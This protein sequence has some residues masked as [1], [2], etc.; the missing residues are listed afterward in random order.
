MNLKMVLFDLDG[1]LLPMDM[2]VFIKCYFGSLI[3]K[4]SESGYDQKLLNDAMKYGLGAM[5]KNRGEKTNEDVFWETFATVYGKSKE[6]CTSDFEQFYEKDFDGVSKSCGFTPEARVCIKKLMDMGLPVALAT[7][8]LFPKI[9]TYKRVKWAGLEPSW[10]RLITTYENSRT[11]KPN[12]AYYV[13][14][15]EA[16]GVAPDRCLMVGN[17]VSDDMV[18]Q[19]LG[20]KV[21]LLDS[22]LIN[23]KGEDISR[24]PHGGFAELMEYIKTLV[25]R[26]RSYTVFS[27]YKQEGY[28]IREPLVLR[29]A[30]LQKEGT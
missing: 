26:L 21:F 25:D 24:Y 19:S 5:M 9:A 14:V 17:D 3:T 13:E 27:P 20:M 23:S 8:P 2:D 16:L 1:T 18:A 29:A 10:F 11:S 4:L 22:C 15:A 28:Q 6:E 7:N 30:S 12:P